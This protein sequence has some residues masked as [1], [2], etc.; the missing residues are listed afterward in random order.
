MSLIE[1]E[2]HLSFGGQQKRF[3]HYSSTLQCEMLFSVYLPPSYEAKA[4]PILYWLSG[5]TCSDE[6]FSTK[7]GAQQYAA[8]LGIILVIPDT[9]PRGEKVADNTSYDLGQG[10]GFY[11]NATQD[12]WQKNYRMLDYVSQELPQLITQNF[13]TNGKQSIAGHSMGGHGALMLALRHPEKYCSAS[14]FAPIVN[15]S[16]VPWGQKAFTAY[17]GEDKAQWQQYDSCYLLQHYAKTPFPI[18][19]DQ[20]TADSFLPEQLKPQ[21]LAEIAK[22]KNWPLTLRLQAGY[23]HSYYFIASFIKDHLVFHS[24]YLNNKPL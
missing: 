1:L 15:P 4:L 24:Q 14:A 3:K 16:D 17:L 18:L 10:A 11:I 5:L 6:N 7:S 13:N 8:E 21:L 19:I 23:D 12:P 9:S 2:S 22:Q 20:G